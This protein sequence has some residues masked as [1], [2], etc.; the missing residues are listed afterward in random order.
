MGSG[1]MR[2]CPD[3]S[4]MTLPCVTIDFG[5]RHCFLEHSDVSFHSSVVNAD[6]LIGIASCLSEAATFKSFILD[7][8][9]V[10]HGLHSWNSAL[11]IL[12][13]PEK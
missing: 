11:K 5:W 10:I 8:A 13:L 4:G 1:C 6:L 7:H 12:F 9:K 3:S 2:H